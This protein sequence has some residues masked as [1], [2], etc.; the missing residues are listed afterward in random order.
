MSEL[1][2]ARYR[3]C[4]RCCLTKPQTSEFFHKNHKRNRWNTWCKVCARLYSAEYRKKNHAKLK[5]QKQEYRDANRELVL[6]QKRQS[7]LRNRESVL[8]KQAATTARRRQRYKEN[9]EK[10]RERSRKWAEA[11]PEKVKQAAREWR[12]RNPERYAI[13]RARRRARKA[14]VEQEPYSA[15]DVSDLWHQQA[16]CCYYCAAPVFATYHV[17]HKQPLS[18][19]GADRLDNL[20]VACPFCN[21]SKKD[22][23]EQEF[24]DY[25]KDN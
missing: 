10:E 3:A 2:L 18:R 4:L 7:Y 15:G 16:G 23:T 11:N 14:S 13:D 20:C 8:A 12:E 21:M 25:R 17:D 24:N 6:E 19:G 5:R 9:A 22:K 1:S